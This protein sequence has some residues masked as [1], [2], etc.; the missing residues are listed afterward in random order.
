MN[1]WQG[2]SNALAGPIRN[3]TVE[4]N[5]LSGKWL[6]WH[7]APVDNVRVVNN[8][9]ADIVAEPRFGLPAAVVDVGN[10]SFKSA[11]RSDN[12]EAACR[13]KL[14]AGLSPASRF[15]P[16]RPG[17]AWLDYDTLPATRDIGGLAQQWM[18]VAGRCG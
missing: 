15:K 5:V 7:S 9:F 17:P 11:Q 10:V 6:S 14:A 18:K 16:E 3:V 4:H 8:L 2:R 13:L 12:P 1:P